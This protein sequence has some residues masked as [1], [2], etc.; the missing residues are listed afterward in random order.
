MTTVIL[1]HEPICIWMLTDISY[2]LLDS[3]CFQYNPKTQSFFAKTQ[4][5]FCPGCLSDLWYFVIKL[6]DLVFV[7]LI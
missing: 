6:F 7:I 5:H 3:A 2:K 4:T 1:R